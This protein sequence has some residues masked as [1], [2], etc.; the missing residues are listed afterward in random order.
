MTDATCPQCDGTGLL[1]GFVDGFRQGRRYG[2]FRRDIVCFTCNGSGRI[3]QHQFNWMEEGRVHREQ[4]K[5]RGESIYAAAARLD[6]SVADLNAM[7]N[8][9]MNPAPLH[10]DDQ[11]G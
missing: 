3:P 6:V 9:R 2:E 10:K 5:E 1:A 8:G 7:E 4:R 11:D